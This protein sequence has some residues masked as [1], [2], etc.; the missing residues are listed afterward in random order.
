[1][2]F[3]ENKKKDKNMK[4]NKDNQNRIERLRKT[5]DFSSVYKYGVSVVT[6]NIVMY[7]KKNNSKSNRI[8]VSVSKKVGKAVIRNKVKRLIK[9]SFRK[10]DLTNLSSGYDIV[11]VARVRIKFADMKIVDRDIT[12]LIKKL[13]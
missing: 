4:E 10:K 2:S 6:K 5:R 3:N 7:Y 11:F 9:E 8:G 13:K 1:M 12:N